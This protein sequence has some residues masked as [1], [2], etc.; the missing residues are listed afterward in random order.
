MDSLVKGEEKEE[1]KAGMRSKAVSTESQMI[2]TLANTSDRFA[3]G[4]DHELFEQAFSRIFAKDAESL[5]KSAA[6]LTACC[7]IS[8]ISF[9]KFFTSL[10]KACKSSQRLKPKT[11]KKEK[12]TDK[13]KTKNL[14]DKICKTSSKQLKQEKKRRRKL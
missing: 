1:E 2:S 12:K 6:L 13:K 9:E 3:Y 11:K 8:K 5:E 4:A 7:M 10:K 14:K